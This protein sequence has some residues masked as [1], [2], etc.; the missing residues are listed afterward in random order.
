[1]A[2]QQRAAGENLRSVTDRN[3]LFYHDMTQMR[4]SQEALSNEL[5]H[6]QRQLADSRKQ[7]EAELAAHAEHVARMVKAEEAVKAVE[8]AKN[9][10]R[11]AQHADFEAQLAGEKRRASARIGELTQQLV[12]QRQRYE[13][14]Q[15][16]IKDIMPTAPPDVAQQLANA[17]AE[18]R[19]RLS[20]ELNPVTVELRE[21][22]ARAARK[23]GG[24]EQR[25][26]TPMSVWPWT[27]SVAGQF[28]NA[29]VPIRAAAES[30]AMTYDKPAIDSVA[31]SVTPA[32]S[33]ERPARSDG[34]N[35]AIE[36]ERRLATPA[37]ADACAG[38][39]GIACATTVQRIQRRLS[40]DALQQRV[41]FTGGP[42]YRPLPWVGTCAGADAA[43]SSEMEVASTAPRIQRQWSNDA[44][45][46]RVAFTGGPDYRPLPWESQPSGGTLD[47]E[48]EL[49]AD[50][51]RGR[52]RTLS[53]DLSRAA[54]PLRGKPDSGCSS[55][56]G[57]IAS[58]SKE[59]LRMP[60]AK[61][62]VISRAAS[63]EAQVKDS[64]RVTTPQRPQQPRP[65]SASKVP[66]WTPIENQKQLP[67]QQVLTSCDIL[68]LMAGG[69]G[70]AR[71]ACI[72]GYTCGT[73]KALERHIARLGPGVHAPLQDQVSLPPP[74]RDSADEAGE[75]PAAPSVAAPTLSPRTA[76]S[77]TAPTGPKVGRR[78]RH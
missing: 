17:I 24:S 13:A 21:M 67:Q 35:S 78:P 48:R 51:V 64:P 20:D 25:S 46:Q 62:R 4:E 34:Q 15:S 44:Q 19:P 28:A 3:D 39:S 65:S 71:T 50:R 38:S 61:D 76:A 49:R 55:T 70:S 12:E 63:Q 8:N 53:A 10:D 41:A 74:T 69:P 37:A 57:S 45:Q 27:Q 30:P 23:E 32:R 66:V 31:R 18:L 52:D 68:G 59:R 75:W 47:R 54:S 73:A 36:V 42:D 72:C 43:S 26:S 11:L 7:Y 16:A 22:A 1:M 14:M 29:S 77:R 9:N 2:D 33:Q 60:A 40:N 56:N 58:C 5:L 6:V